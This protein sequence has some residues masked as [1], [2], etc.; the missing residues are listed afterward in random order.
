MEN[1][2]EVDALAMMEFLEDEKGQVIPE[3]PKEESLKEVC[4]RFSESIYKDE[5]A[6]SKENPS[7]QLKGS[8][9][10][11]NPK[12]KEKPGL[13][14]WIKDNP[15]QSLL[16]GAL[17]AGGGYMLYKHL[18]EKKEEDKSEK[19]ETGSSGLAGKKIK[20]IIKRKKNEESESEKEK[21][22]VDST[23]KKGENKQ[24][25]AEEEKEKTISGKD[26]GIGIAAALGGSI[27]GAA[28]GDSSL[29][30]SIPV[31]VAGIAKS[32]LG[33]SMAGAGMA[34][35][36]GYKSKD[37]K[38]EQ[39]FLKGIIE[40]IINYLSSLFEKLFPFKNKEQRVPEGAINTMLG[41]FFP[42]DLKQKE[43]I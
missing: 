27:V 35:A 15:I 26:L 28:F 19:K 25:E 33:I 30:A 9:E 2:R 31:I 6:S 17:I 21:S 13:S 39:G 7:E 24:I 18:T 36:G 37:E 40:R 20:L 1:G 12:K 23:I 43:A 34:L 14:E 29:L 42:T 11:M 4:K 3:K 32:S 10:E 38:S 16:I 22:K 5:T 8:S 41:L